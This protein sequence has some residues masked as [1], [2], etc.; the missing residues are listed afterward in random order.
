MWPARRR[1]WCPR[2][3]LPGRWSIGSRAGRSIRGRAGPGS[4]R[5]P[6]CPRT[7]DRA[8]A[9]AGSRPSVV[10]SVSVAFKTPSLAP[11][12]SSELTLISRKLPGVPMPPQ[13]DSSVAVPV[14]SLSPAVMVMLT[15]VT[16]ASEPTPSPIASTIAPG[17][18]SVTS[19]AV[20]MIRPTRRS[21]LFSASTML[22]LVRT[23]MWCSS[24]GPA[25]KPVPTI[26]VMASMLMIFGLAASGSAAVMM[27]LPPAV[28][29]AR[30][31]LPA[32][33]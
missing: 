27:M 31:R 30:V 14:M 18:N 22:P 5:R 23:S 11:V 3:R 19:P 28:M 24:V 4:G 21:P 7:P 33:S 29:P 32:E 16:L 9:P 15:P 6:R 20:D 8:A 13:P 26:W 1:P 12:P 25:T 10:A 2:C 17:E